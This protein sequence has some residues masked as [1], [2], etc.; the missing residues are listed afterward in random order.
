MYPLRAAAMVERRKGD[1]RKPA[2]A[3]PAVTTHIP[4]ARV[5][6]HPRCWSGPALGALS[7]CLEERGFDTGANFRIG[8]LTTHNRRELVREINQVGAV[9]MYE[10][11]D[12]SRYEHRMGCLAPEPEV[13]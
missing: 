12:G 11:M 6:I 7:S 5:F 4:S 3:Q 8:P 13:A 10:R 2:I 1:R 9:T